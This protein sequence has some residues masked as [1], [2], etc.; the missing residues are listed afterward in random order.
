M[1]RRRKNKR[2][3]EV[4]IISTVVLLCIMT[5]GYAAFQTNLNISA[6]GNVMDKGITPTELKNTYCNQTSGDG[7]YKDTYE[8]GR[9]IYKGANPNNYVTFNDEL[10]RIISVENDG[11]LKIIKNNDIGMQR[12]DST[13]LR[14]TGYCS[15]SLALEYGCNAWMQSSNFIN[16]NLS[17]VV[18]KDA[19]LNTHLNTTYYGSLNSKSKEKIINYSW[20]V[21]AVPFNSANLQTQITQEN[22]IKWSGYVALP[23]VSE[24]IRTSIN[25][26]CTNLTSYYYSADGSCW[27]NGESHNWLYKVLTNNSTK[28]G[29]LLNAHQDAYSVFCATGQNEREGSIDRAYSRGSARLYAYP[30]VYLKFDIYLKGLGTETDPYIIK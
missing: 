6:K 14:T 27:K 17:G 19:E 21:G 5:S 12:Y 7:L 24:Y 26:K 9:C 29:W 1:R 11:K 13:G 2:Q 22:Q 30:T 20:G 3:R 16:G 23:S 28:I 25:P 10:W 4:I 15:N 8:D 18:N